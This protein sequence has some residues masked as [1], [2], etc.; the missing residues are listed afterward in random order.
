MTESEYD[1]LAVHRMELRNMVG[2]LRQLPE[3]LKQF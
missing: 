2:I 3:L 1:V